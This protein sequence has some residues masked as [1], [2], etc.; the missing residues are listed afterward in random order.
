MPKNAK[1]KPLN[2]RRRRRRTWR[3]VLARLPIHAIKLMVFG[4]YAVLVIPLFILC[5]GTSAV[6][7]A[8]VRVAESWRSA[9]QA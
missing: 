5:M 9:P 7:H 3:H 2:A 6:A 1:I 4:I 8:A